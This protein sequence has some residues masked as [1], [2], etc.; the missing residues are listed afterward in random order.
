MNKLLI[1]ATTLLL[2]FGT[3]N[4]CASAPDRIVAPSGGTRDGA[5]EQ[6]GSNIWE[7]WACEESDDQTICDTWIQDDDGNEFY[8]ETE[9][10][11]VRRV[12]RP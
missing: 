3:G 6:T 5:C 4:V 7:C 9:T 11:P 10:R 8:R 1:C 12:T 2:T